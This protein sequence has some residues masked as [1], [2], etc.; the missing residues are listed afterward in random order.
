M[1]VQ[2]ALV[3][4]WAATKVGGHLAGNLAANYFLGR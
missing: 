1:L 3:I 2:P 4:F